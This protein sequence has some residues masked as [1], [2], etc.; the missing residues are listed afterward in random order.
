MGAETARLDA[1]IVNSIVL[2]AAATAGAHASAELERS[3]GEETMSDETKND[4]VVVLGGTT[5]EVERKK[6][7]HAKSKEDARDATTSADPLMCVMRFA[8]VFRDDRGCPLAAVRRDGRTQLLD[9]GGRPF[10][11][12]LRRMLLDAGLQM[13]RGEQRDLREQLEGIAL[14]TGSAE[15]VFTRVAGTTEDSICI[16][17]GTSTDDAA[18]VTSRGWQVVP[19]SP[20]RFT[21][22]AGT[23][24]LPRPEAACYRGVDGL[25]SFLNLR[26]QDFPL[27]IGWLLGALR[28]RGPYPILILQGEQGTGKST[29]ARILTSLVDPRRAPLRT[30]PRTERDLA[31]A[32][33]HAHVLSYDNLSGISAAMSDALCRASTGGG[34]STRR[35]HTDSNEVVLEASRPIIATGIDEIATRPDLAERAILLRLPVVQGRVDEKTLM[36]EFEKAAPSIFGSILD[37]LVA[38]LARIDSVTIDELPRMADFARWVTAA[39]PGLGWPEGTIVG[40]YRKMQAEQTLDSFSEDPVAPLIPRLLGLAGGDEWA[41]TASELFD[42]LK[43]M[44]DTTH[45]FPRAPNALTAHLGRIAPLLRAKGYSFRSERT[46]AMRKLILERSS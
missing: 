27:A 23:L 39:E 6:A 35:L 24:P 36:R 30:L 7:E 42:A 38:A 2:R 29:A 33:Q 10:K 14:F 3:A 16:D 26:G 1:T 43:K 32:A 45:G 12:W 13:T 8:H 41:G 34:L 11:L 20:M 37:G 21:T 9:V 4:N 19:A 46:Q 15:R 28:P 22:S 44:T 40:A 5:D 31:V 18:R 17:L 25:R